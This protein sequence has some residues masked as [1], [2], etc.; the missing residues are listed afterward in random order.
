MT[1]TFVE[2]TLSY[3]SGILR[4]S[5]PRQLAARNIARCAC[6]ALQT[7]A[8]VALLASATHA[9]TIVVD[10]NNPTPGDDFTNS[11][12]SNTTPAT[13]GALLGSTG[14]TYN[15]VRNN[16]HVG[17]NTDYPRSGNGSVWFNGTQG[18]SGSSSKA[19]IEYF[20]TDGNGN[21]AA[22][23]TLGDITALAYDWYKSSASSASQQAN[24]RIYID[25]DGNLATTS[26]EG[27]LVFERAY[28]T[29]NSVPTDQWI[30]DNV[31]NANLWEVYFGHGN[32]DT[33]GN[34]Q[35]LSV[36]GSASGFTPSGGGLHLDANSVIFGL[37]SGI[38]SGWAPYLGAVDNITIGFGAND[39]TT[40]NFEVVPE[41]ATWV[42]A[43][44]GLVGWSILARR[45]RGRI[46]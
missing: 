28:Q 1:R 46:A 21:L 45:R 7:A 33:A 40:Y 34:F 36:W 8:A 37:N 43:A 32:F 25:G 6:V 2:L 18:P 38:G 26:D 12:S 27:Y 13:P 19:D 14:W 44:M 31:I 17:I 24:L 16:G 29:D 30:T 5:H 9:A 3:I 15:N 11:T 10:A 20:N 35:P 4:S 39:P 41:P 23:G 42:L 22:M